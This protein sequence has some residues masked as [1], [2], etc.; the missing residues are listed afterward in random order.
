MHSSTSSSEMPNPMPAHATAVL[1]DA[2]PEMPIPAHPWGRI[3]LSTCLL[4]L[5]FLGAWEAHWRARGYAPSYEDT[6]GFWTMERERL[7]RHD[8]AVAIIGSSRIRFG[9]DQQLVE[10]AHPDRAV[11]NL[12]MNGSVPGPVLHDLAEDPNFRGL[13]VCDYTPI[14]FW[15]PGGPLY[16]KTNEWV[17]YGKKE[18]VA[19]R[20]G[21]RLS[22]GPDSMLAF[23]NKEDLTLNAMLE[24]LDVPNRDGLQLPP[25]YPPYFSSTARDRSQKM[26]SRAEQDTAFQDHIK[27]VWMGLFSLAQPLPPELLAMIRGQIAADVAKIRERGGDVIFVRFP[28]SGDLLELERAITP[29][30]THWDMLLAE[31]GCLGIHFEDYPEL[32]AYDCP[33]WSHL[34]S[35]DSVTFTRELL[36]IIAT[37][38]GETSGAG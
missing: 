4:A 9:L 11:V 7:R 5:V 10:Q 12:S 21:Q 33:E 8:D 2:E 29:R 17:Q 22:F 15:M 32:A 34:T 14:L 16:D 30:E 27:G 24:R 23:L 35:T 31:T 25:A 1:P 20:I 37:E 6:P 36:R 18:T 13:V 26:W 19:A 38:R 28:S 3:L